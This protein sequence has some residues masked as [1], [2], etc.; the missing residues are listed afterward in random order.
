VADEPPILLEISRHALVVLVGVSGSGKS[1]FAALHFRPTEVLSSDRFRAMIADDEADQSVSAAAF[2]LLHLVARR[3]LEA[4]RLAVVD[5]TSTTPGA[6][7]QLLDIAD[8]LGVPAVALVLD[9]PVRVCVARDAARSDRSVGPEVI[10]TQAEALTA[11]L[12]EIGNEGFARTYLLRG[13]EEVARARIVREEGSGVR[14][15]GS[16]VSTQ[17]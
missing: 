6:R 17:E 7:R 1:S 4:G 3:R 13:E 12:P 15:Q 2:E 11:S 16:G 10:R 14:G 5:A 8:T 9:V